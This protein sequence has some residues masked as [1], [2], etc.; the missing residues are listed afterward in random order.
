[1]VKYH[2][3]RRL[4]SDIG[5]LLSTSIWCL[6]YCYRMTAIYL[7]FHFGAMMVYIGGSKSVCISTFRAW[8]TNY[9]TSIHFTGTE[10]VIHAY[11]K[12]TKCMKWRAQLVIQDGA[13]RTRRLRR[14]MILYLIL[15]ILILIPR[16]RKFP[17]DNTQRYVPSNWPNSVGSV[18]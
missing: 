2:S 4:D 18:G 16:R 5:V 8:K 7:F 6:K 10:Q 11:Y 9:E 15:R 13:A 3:M 17:K 1:M 12:I 14:W